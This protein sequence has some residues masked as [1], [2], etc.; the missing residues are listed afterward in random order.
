MKDLKVLLVDDEIDF[1][2]TLAERLELRGVQAQTAPDGKT[3]LKL[4]QSDQPQW[5]GSRRFKRSK[6]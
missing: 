3:A 6:K 1:V 5:M 4:V 2:A